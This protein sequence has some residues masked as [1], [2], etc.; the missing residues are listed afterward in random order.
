MVQKLKH[1]LLTQFQL[2]RHKNIYIRI[3][4]IR[5]S[6]LYKSTSFYGTYHK[7]NLVL[8]LNVPLCHPILRCCYLTVDGASRFHQKT[9]RHVEFSLQLS[10]PI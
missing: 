8:S 10:P 6:E 1:L 7:L 5:A 3:T 4:E 2:V 9:T